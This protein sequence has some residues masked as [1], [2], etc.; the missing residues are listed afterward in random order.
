MKQRHFR[1]GPRAQACGSFSFPG[2]I[3]SSEG[4]AA[5]AV[6]E[7][8]GKTA[9][10]S[11]AFVLRQFG[12]KI[13][14]KKEMENILFPGE[15]SPGN[16]FRI[17]TM[18]LEKNIETLIAAGGGKTLDLAKYLKRE[19]PGLFLINIPTSAATCAAATPV[20]VMYDEKGVYMDTLDVLCPDTVIIDYEIF[21]DLPMPFF[22][23]GAI[24][25]MAKYYETA[26]YCENTKKPNPYDLFMLQT[27][28]RSYMRLKKLITEKWLR[29]DLALKKELADLIITQSAQLSCLGRFTVTAG[30]AHALAHSVTASAGARQYLHGEH[31]AA[32]LIIQEQYLKNEERLKEIEN[33][34]AIM[35]LPASF[36]GLGVTKKE[37][38]EV[39]KLYNALI[40]REKIYIPERDDMVY[41]IIRSQY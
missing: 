41:N 34:A 20:S 25:A 33:L 21:Y 35:D 8:K 18:L 5:L 15:C 36:M 31:V 11:D 16:F 28:K 19:I 9:L 29:P 10:L 37:L 6:F 2:K 1:K 30:L 23:A 13:K 3:I 39:E 17:K 22:A 32:G 12:P 7:A 14:N 24:D 40:S 26:A 38:P 27:I 4:A